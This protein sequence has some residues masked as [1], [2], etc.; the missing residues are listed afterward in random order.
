MFLF[1]CL[2]SN[3]KQF[4]IYHAI[5]LCI[6]Q[7]FSTKINCG[8]YIWHFIIIVNSQKMPLQFWMFKTFLS[9][10]NH[11]W[12]KSTINA[13]SIYHFGD[14]IF[15]LMSYAHLLE[16]MQLLTWN[17]PQS[18]QLKFILYKPPPQFYCFTKP[19]IKCQL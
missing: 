13:T 5:F 8:T 18:S 1:V 19:L 10:S 15:F 14:V 3:T 4:N 9:T 7:C 16:I 2:F 17:F 11:N 6:F 12:V